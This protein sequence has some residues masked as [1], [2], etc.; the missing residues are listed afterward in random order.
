RFSRDWSSDVCSSDLQAAPALAELVARVWD[1][2]Y[3]SFPPTSLQVSNIHA[4]TG[5]NNVIP[6]ELQ[7]LFNLRYNP[8]WD[9][10]KLEAEIAAL[11]DRHGLDHEL[12]WHRSGEPFYTPEGTLRVA[13]REVLSEVAGAPPEESTGGGT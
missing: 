12:R 2:G 7:V 9:A 1:E 11:L 13:A 10:P 8:H 5:A 3:E 6:G 4:G